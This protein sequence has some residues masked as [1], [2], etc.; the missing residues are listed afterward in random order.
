MWKVWSFDIFIN[1]CELIEKEKVIWGK[2]WCKDK[3]CFMYLLIYCIFVVS[4]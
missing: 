1:K 2:I 4:M 3:L